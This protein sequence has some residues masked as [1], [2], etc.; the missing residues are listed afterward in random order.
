MTSS[1]LKYLRDVENGSRLIIETPNQVPKELRQKIKNSINC[2]LGENVTRNERSRGTSTRNLNPP[3][4]GSATECVIMYD[5]KQ[6]GCEH[7][8]V[9]F[10]IIPESCR[11]NVEFAKSRCAICLYFER[12]LL[13]VK[14]GRLP[15]AA[16]VRFDKQS[17]KQS[18]RDVL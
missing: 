15:N 12:L 11:V 9:Q 13:M 7:F 3:L 14:N 1:T 17:E 8:L 5:L 16:I 4:Y 10:D 6:S 18:P 2:N